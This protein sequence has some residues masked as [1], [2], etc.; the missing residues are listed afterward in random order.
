PPVLLV[1]ALCGTLHSWYGVMENLSLHHHVIA[2]DLRGHG[3]S[4]PAGGKLSIATFAE[5]VAAL[6][7]ALELPAV[8]LVGHSMGT[9]IAQHLAATQ[10]EL[11]DNLVLIGGI[12]WFEP[13]LRK[14]YEQRAEAVEADGLDAVVDEW[15]PGALAPGT[16]AK[17]P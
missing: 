17:L 13:P 8:T 10:P 7:A 11:V 16:H 5:D 3:R 12:S 9:L 6:I 2:L 15:L 14:A 4:G 1:H